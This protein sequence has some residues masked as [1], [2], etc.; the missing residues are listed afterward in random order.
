VVRERKVGGGGVVVV[1]G[2][3]GWRPHHHTNNPMPRLTV[4]PWQARPAFATHRDVLAMPWR[5]E[6]IQ[7]LQLGCGW[8]GGSDGPQVPNPRLGGGGNASQEHGIAERC[9]FKPFPMRRSGSKGGRLRWII[10]LAFVVTL[11][12]MLFM[13]MSLSTLPHGN[14]GG[15]APPR[16]AVGRPRK[17]G[18]EQGQPGQPGPGKLTGLTP[19]KRGTL[20]QVT[21]P[22]PP[23]FTEGGRAAVPSVKDMGVED[24]LAAVA[25]ANTVLLSQSSAHPATV[26][27]VSGIW[28]IGRGSMA[29]SPQ[30]DTMNRPFSY[31]VDGLRKFLAYNLP[32]VLFVDFDTY[33][34]IHGLVDE[35]NAAASASRLGATRVIIRSLS[36]IQRDFGHS[37][38]VD[39]I[40]SRQQWL[41]QGEGVRNSP[42]AL[43]PAYVP[44][45]MSKLRFTRDAARWNP[46]STEAF[47]WLDGAWGPGCVVR[48][49][50]WWRCM[51][52]CPLV[53]LG[54]HGKPR[55]PHPPPHSRTPCRR[56]PPTP[57]QILHQC[58]TF[59]TRRTRSG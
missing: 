15:D 2:G 36:D 20:S 4:P 17:G 14:E 6:Y 19:H 23:V 43:L 34:L 24:A 55:S 8:Q 9:T 28:N 52:V 46:F 31:Y 16:P 11:G 27:L 26:T 39:G 10:V 51:C 40:R 37:E 30:W 13:F 41:Q 47:L 5:W 50:G 48:A 3:G 21:L 22:S 53:T 18:G 44:L 58:P 57:P 45:V 35:A 38:L 7:N 32:K 54:R 25:H 12:T 42:Q 33:T 1:G 56:I 59:A 29:T 49:G